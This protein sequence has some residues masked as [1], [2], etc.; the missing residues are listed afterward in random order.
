MILG[1]GGETLANGIVVIVRFCNK[2]KN[3]LIDFSAKDLWCGFFIELVDQWERLRLDEF[4][5]LVDWALAI[6]DDFSLVE[7]L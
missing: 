4:N 1:G 7:I 5:Q 2:E 6:V 3:V